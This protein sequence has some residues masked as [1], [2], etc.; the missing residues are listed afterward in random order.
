MKHL[1]LFESFD[2]NFYR[3]IQTIDFFGVNIRTFT[4]SEL[5]QIYDIVDK[6][7]GTVQRHR[8]DS[9]ITV[10]IPRVR[11]TITFDE[12]TNVKKGDDEFYYVAYD[13]MGKKDFYEADQF[14]GL[15][16]LLN[17]IL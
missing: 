17:D 11:G 16:K 5:V 1:K 6:K 12:H 9:I 2:G 10:H 15:L 8:T 7:G 14:D 3:R 4:E 13:I